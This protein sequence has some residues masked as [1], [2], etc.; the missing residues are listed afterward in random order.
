[1]L[2]AAMKQILAFGYILTHLHD[3][4]SAFVEKQWEKPLIIRHNGEDYKIYLKVDKAKQT[5]TV[6]GTDEPTGKVSHT[7]TEIELTLPIPDEVKNVG[8][9][10]MH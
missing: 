7:D 5:E 4:G 9:Q 10:D 1:M 2:G 6:R 3:D 8:M